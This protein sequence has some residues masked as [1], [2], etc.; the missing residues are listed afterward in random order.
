M[1]AQEVTT[2]TVAL[3]ATLAAN[4]TGPDDYQV[5]FEWTQLITGLYLIPVISL[6]G[7]L[8]SLFNIVIYKTSQKCST[9]VYLIALSL[10]DIVKLF[11]DFLYFIVNLA[12]KLDE[13][14]GQ[15]IFKTLYLYSHFVFVVTAINT[16]WLTCL[17]AFDRYILIVHAKPNSHQRM[18]NKQMQIRV[19]FKSIV[20][21]AVILL[22]SIIIAIP[23][24]I[25]HGI[26][27]DEQEKNK[28]ENEQ[29]LR[30]LYNY[31]QAVI[32]A[33]VPLLIIV[34]LNIRILQTV[35][36][37]KMKNKKKAT[38]SSISGGAARP[39]K[40]KSSIT[41]MLILIVFSFVVCIFPDVIL[42]M[43]HLGYANEGY[44]I[45]AIRECTDLLLTINSSTTFPICY[46]FSI[47]Y[48]QKFKEI[49]CTKSSCCQPNDRQSARDTAITG[50]TTIRLTATDS[51]RRNKPN[52]VGGETLLAN[53]V[54]LEEDQA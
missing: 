50:N 9:H 18:N 25:F 47:H 7:I 22:C 1:S 11:N 12:N 4:K 21:S 10:S 14:L 37:N 49:F 23:S 2:T 20:C 17:I 41:L 3:T 36:K 30:Q 13:Q 26:K 46:Y 54:P 33:F 34:Y 53:K 42:T 39:V 27:S 28:I 40:S 52:E 44:L 15:R 45:R 51:I 48:R 38:T 35:Y 24:P 29:R 6:F 5:L 8:G 31:F 19:Y 43:M 16:A 32:K